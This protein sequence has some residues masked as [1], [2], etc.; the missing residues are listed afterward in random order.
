MSGDLRPDEA[1]MEEVRAGNRAA[2]QVLYDRHHRSVFGFLLR[3]LGERRAAED[4]LQETFLRVFAHREEYRSTA[5]FRGW[6]FTIARNLLID[7]LRRKSGS[8]DVESRENL[9]A[10]ADPGAT[11][12]QQAEAWELDER[13]QEAVLRLTPS[14]R[15]V[16]LLSRF[17]GLSA[18]EIAEVTGSSPEAVRVTLHRALLRLRALLGML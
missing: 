12:L 13:L 1:L 3:S 8:P 16:L 18:A 9:E 15:D 7:Q 4:L 5:S 10:V 2:F 6:L 14:Q 11:P 17:T